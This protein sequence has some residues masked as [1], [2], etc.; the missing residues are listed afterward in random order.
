MSQVLPTEH[1]TIDQWPLVVNFF[2][3][4][5][6]IIVTTEIMLPKLIK[7]QMSVPNG[8]STQLPSQGFA[9]NN[10]KKLFEVSYPGGQIVW[11]DLHVAKDRSQ[12]IPSDEFF[13]QEYGPFPENQNVRCL[14]ESLNALVVWQYHPPSVF[15]WVIR[16]GLRFRALAICL[17]RTFRAI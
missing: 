15:S 5:I 16:L 13:K 12:W 10:S 2:Q 7:V 1:Q 6:F 14:D 4:L 9:T 17:F 11:R 3:F 8:D